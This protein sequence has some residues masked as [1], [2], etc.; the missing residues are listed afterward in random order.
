MDSSVC[1]CVFQSWLMDIRFY[2]LQFH[3]WYLAPTLRMC[4]CVSNFH[5]YLCIIA[6]FHVAVALFADINPTLKQLNAMEI[7]IC[8]ESTTKIHKMRWNRLINP[9]LCSTT[10]IKRGNN[11]KR[12]HSHSRPSNKGDSRHDAY[13]LSR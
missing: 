6:V 4:E 8:F 2:V 7:A 13:G 11:N 10:H 1:V 12:T 5:H 9:K 3:G